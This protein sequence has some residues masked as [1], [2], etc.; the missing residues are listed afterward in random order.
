M[1]RS[2]GCVRKLDELNRL[3]IPKELTR[4]MNFA[5]RQA[6]EIYVDGEKIILQK[7]EPACIFCNEIKNGMVNYK[8]KIL[9]PDCVKDMSKQV[10]P[11]KTTSKR[12]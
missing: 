11:D 7:Y 3:V 9:C 5:E 2:T 4:T 8:G 12:R 10:V 6:M 1:M